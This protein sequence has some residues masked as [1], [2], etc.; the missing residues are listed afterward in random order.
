MRKIWHKAV[1]LLRTLISFIRRHKV[2]L[3]LGFTLTVLA[4]GYLW[5]SWERPMYLAYDRPNCFANL[6]FLPNLYKQ[7]ADK[8]Y[9]LSTQKPVKIGNYPLISRQTCINLNKTPLEASAQRL[10]LA[11]LDLPV[12]KKN[13][14]VMAG[15]HPRLDSRIAGITISVKEPLIFKLDKTDKLFTYHLKVGDK[16]AQCDISNDQVICP[17]QSLGLLQGAQY[18]VRIEKSYKVE[19]IPL[20]KRQVHTVTP[21]NL[22][23]QS[24]IQ[25]SIVY[26]TPTEF[27]L[28]ADKPLLQAEVDL[29]QVV[30]ATE[31]KKITQSS[32]V[33]DKEIVVKPSEQLPRD[34]D[35]ELVVENATATDKGVLVGPY[36]L[37]FKLSGGPRVAAVSIGTRSVD[38]AASITLTFDQKV[39]PGHDFSKLLTF[40]DGSNPIEFSYTF[41]DQKLVIQPKARRPTCSHLRLELSGVITSMYNV[42][43]NYTWKYSSR[44][45]CYT[46]TTIGYSAQGRAIQTWRF[47]S[48]PSKILYVA[49][50]HGNEKSTKYLMDK[51]LNEL[52]A[53]PDKIPAQRT[54]II[55][56]NLNPD[57]FATASRRNA[58]NVDLNRN[59]PTSNWKADVTMPGG[60]LIVNG[61]GTEPLSESESKVLS[62]FVLAQNPRLVITYHSVASIVTGTGSGDSVGLAGTYSSLSGYR[63]LPASQTGDVFHY[64]TTGAFEDWL[65]E[66]IS[67]PALLV[68]LGSHTN[69]EFSRNKDAMWA[70]AKL[71]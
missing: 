27:K 63:N 30:S 53:N 56:P 15:V 33:F 5:H 29:W 39:A 28:L 40:S 26:D 18:E 37:P 8:T 38:P 71:P 13:F 61:G 19:K 6:T 2:A 7:K 3:S 45:V 62:N 59:F 58:R 57:G 65:H 43:G 16:H 46:V 49:A 12:L 17:V 44:I 34:T 32:R 42:S 25:N 55:I 50:T 68:E 47:G 69:H 14:K 10:H 66:K 64:D 11:F 60:E 20:A 35:Y 9:S 31:R 51:W 4:T 23:G 21:V 1:G 24:I 70:M 36:K 54:I 52:E 22:T 41:K 48:G 67:I